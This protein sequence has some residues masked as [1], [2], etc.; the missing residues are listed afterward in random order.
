[1]GIYPEY[2]MTDMVNNGAQG[3]TWTEL[4]ETPGLVEERQVKATGWTVKERTDCYCCSCTEHLTDAACRNHG[5]AAKRPCEAHEM[6][7]QEWDDGLPGLG[8]NM[9]VSVQV[10][11]ARRAGE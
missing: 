3:A 6:P 10:A 5:W 1:M 9:P 8:T 7:G 2:R 11:R 4:R